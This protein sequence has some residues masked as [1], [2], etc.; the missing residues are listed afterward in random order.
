M[1]NTY[2]YISFVAVSLVIVIFSEL[3]GSSF[4]DKFNDDFIILIS[5]IFTINVAS[6]SIIYTRLKEISISID[7][8]EKNKDIATQI[9]NHFTKAKDSLSIGFKTQIILIGVTFLLQIILHSDVVLNCYWYMAF[10]TMIIFIFIYILEL[11]YDLGECII[12]LFT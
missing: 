2:K 3:I 4:L 9:K 11:T 1:N 5:T 6:T 8:N 10:N 7:E 12:E